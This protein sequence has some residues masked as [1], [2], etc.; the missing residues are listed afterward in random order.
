MAVVVDHPVDDEYAE[1]L[2]DRRDFYDRGFGVMTATKHP[3]FVFSTRGASGLIHKVS[4]VTMHWWRIGRGGHALVKLKRPVMI[5]ETNCT[6]SFRLEGEKART[7]WIPNPDALLCGRCHGDVA[8]FG[9][10]GAA[11]K[12][13]I[14]RTEAHVKLGCVVTGY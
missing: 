9:K 11:T 8:T 13:G 3:P 4:R 10:H 6:M 12:A 2:H 5:A 7:C 14:R 1:V